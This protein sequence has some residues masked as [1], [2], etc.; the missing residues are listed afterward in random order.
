MQFVLPLAHQPAGSHHQC[1]AQIPPQHQLLD[2]QACHNRLPG[3]RVIGQAEPQRL[4]RQ[5]L[6]VHRRDLMRQ[7]LDQAEMNRQ[8]RIKQVSQPDPASL[9][10]KP[11]QCAIA[12]ERPR[13]ARPGQAQLALLRP[14]DE[15]LVHPADVGPECQHHA[16]RARPARRHNSHRFAGDHAAHDGSRRQLL[17]F[18]HGKLLT[19]RSLLLYTR[20]VTATTERPGVL[21]GGIRVLGDADL[22]CG[23]I[24]GLNGSAF[25]PVHAERAEARH[26]ISTHPLRGAGLRALGTHQRDGIADR[27]ASAAS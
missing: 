19:A 16:P 8:T 20:A 15:L 21:V 12:V 7:R 22:R 6:P 25:G 4:P 11:E 18:R 27:Q 9:R 24:P 26:A 13:P 10:N 5:H 3:T 17:K 2:I 14:V 23:R 1:A